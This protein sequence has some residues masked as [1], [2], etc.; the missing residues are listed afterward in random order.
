MIPGIE[1]K[2]PFNTVSPGAILITS[3][4]EGQDR[5]ALQ[6][7]GH[8]FSTTHDSAGQPWDSM[9]TPAWEPGTDLLTLLINLAGRACSTGYAYEA[10]DDA[11]L[12][13]AASAILI[14]SEASL[15]RPVATS[16]FTADSAPSS[17]GRAWRFPL[18]YTFVP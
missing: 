7:L 6:G 16:G 18:C 5:G 9:L 11:T 15:S 8:D 1:G 13:D 4:Q 12:E 2:R 3:I 10:P 14:Q 17:S